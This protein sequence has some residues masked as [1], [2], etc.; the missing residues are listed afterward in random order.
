MKI[1]E[2]KGTAYSQ[3]HPFSPPF[4]L[5]K[6]HCAKKHTQDARHHS[7]VNLLFL[8]EI[9]R[10]HTVTA[11]LVQKLQDVVHADRRAL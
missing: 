6:V 10:N 2:T 9:I 4:C 7:A 5:I 1:A 11:G 8:L 3:L